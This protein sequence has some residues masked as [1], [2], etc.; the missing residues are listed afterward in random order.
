SLVPVSVRALPGK[1][2]FGGVFC[3]R[4]KCSD[5][6]P[7]VIRG[8]HRD[9]VDAPIGKVFRAGEKQ[10]GGDLRSLFA[11]DAKRIKKR[12]QPS[13]CARSQP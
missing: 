5:P 3:F 8:W 9:Q 1:P 2:R 6:V 4:L 7:S 13:F 11:F 12:L 10:G